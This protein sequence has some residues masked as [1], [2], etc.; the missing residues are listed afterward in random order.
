MKPTVEQLKNLRTM[1]RQYPEF[2]DYLSA[3]RMK[4]LE[5][6]PFAKDNVGVQQGRVQTLTEMQRVL[7]LD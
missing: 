2:L 4:E 5:A 1:I 7:S 6:L 3:W